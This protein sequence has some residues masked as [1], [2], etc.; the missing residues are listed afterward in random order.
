MKLTNYDKKLELVAWAKRVQAFAAGKDDATGASQ[1]AR[2][3]EEFESGRFTLAILGRVKSGKST[4]CN[5]WLGCKDDILAPIGVDPATSV[6]TKFI[7]DASPAAVIHY[8]DG[9]TESVGFDAVRNYLTEDENLENRKDVRYV[10]VK[11]DFRGLEPD[12]MLVDTPGAGSLHAHH[13]A[14]LIEFLPEADAAIF[15]CSATTFDTEVQDLLK[16]WKEHTG[17]SEAKKLFFAV[18]K[19]DLLAGNEADLRGSLDHNRNLLNSIGLNVSQ[20]W[21]ISAEKAYKD[22]DLAASGIQPMLD[23]IREFFRVEK[24]DLRQ[25]NFIQRVACVLRTHEDRMVLAENLAANSLSELDK[26]QADLHQELGKLQDRNKLKVLKFTQSYK[27]ACDNYK[28]ALRDAEPKCI[29]NAHTLIYETWAVA[30]TQ[31]SSTLPVQLDSI[32]ANAL[33]PPTETFIQEAK[34]AVDQFQQE[35]ELPSVGA[36]AP[37]VHL[38]PGTSTRSFKVSTAAQILLSTTIATTTITVPTVVVSTLASIPLVGSLLGVAAAGL[39]APVVVPAAGIAMLAAGHGGWKMW[40]AYRAAKLA[41]KDELAKECEAQVQRLF[42][43][44]ISDQTSR[45]EEIK[46]RVIEE[47]ACTGIIWW[48]FIGWDRGLIH[49]GG[50]RYRS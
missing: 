50:R 7:R 48:F 49:L 5:A 18:N 30:V 26:L 36:L 40:A 15:L 34:L 11:S 47:Y 43:I 46:S 20:I 25:V 1:I 14:L 42:R 22:G 31:L 10:E 2:A 3:I 38:P 6:V 39:L 23:A 16:Q 12:L 21:P 24:D 29:K 4:F 32:V 45:L 9:H 41:K 35:I 37:G 13:D 17:K 27:K 33:K 28:D 44:V 19:V 8:R